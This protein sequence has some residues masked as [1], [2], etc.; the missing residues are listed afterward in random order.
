MI[1]GIPRERKTHEYRVG[2]T[3]AAVKQLVQAGH[4]V[5]VEAGAGGGAGFGDGD[6]LAAGAQVVATNEE[7]Y[8]ESE[9]LVKVKEPEPQEFSLL[10]KGHVLFAFLHLAAN[11]ELARAL[12]EREVVAIAY[13]TVQLDDGSLP[14]LVP[15]SEVAGKLSVQTGAHWLQKENQGSGVLLGGVAGVPPGEVVVIGAGTVGTNAARVA[16]GLGAKVTVFDVDVTRLRR[17]GEVLGERVSLV[18]SNPSAV[19]EAVAGADVV[20]GAVLVPGARAPKVVTKEMIH[21]M[22]P[23]SVIVDVAIDQGGCVE[24]AIP[25]THDAA[26]IRVGPVLLYGVVNLPASVSRTSTFALVNATFPY[27]ARLADLGYQEAVRT[28]RA[29]RRGLNVVGGK[30]TCQA[31]AESLGIT[32]CPYKDDSE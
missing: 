4:R 13:E 17:L 32:Y 3:P 7:L 8:G 30:V 14:L 16:A 18:A 21:D 25:T 29:L 24:G 31:V 22:R 12:L 23:G 26:V 27:V 9:L 28:D 19:A 1:I 5:L 11:P 6:Y 20:V 10:R 2:L 15:M